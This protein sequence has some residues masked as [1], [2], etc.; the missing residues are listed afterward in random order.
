M[1][2]CSCWLLTDEAGFNASIY[3]F[4]STNAI[5][6][7]GKPAEPRTHLD[8]LAGLRRSGLRW[9]GLGF[10][11]VGSGWVWSKVEGGR[12]KDKAEETEMGI[13]AF[14]TVSACEVARGSALLHH[15]HVFYFYFY[16]VRR[17]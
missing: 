17:Q 3:L 11:I 4:C 16:R 7:E 13:S 12:G 2:W 6:N 5:C 8:G 1:C 10:H 15:F 14:Y 9:L